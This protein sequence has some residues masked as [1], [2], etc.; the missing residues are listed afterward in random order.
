MLNNVTVSW[1]SQLQQIISLSTTGDEYVATIR[2]SKK[3]I[4]L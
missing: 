4:W 1:A 2:A 3:M